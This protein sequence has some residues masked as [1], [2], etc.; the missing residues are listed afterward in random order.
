MKGV[1]L[2]RHP[3]VQCGPALCYGAADVSLAAG[4]EQ[5]AEQLAQKLRQ[6]QVDRLWSSPLSRCQQPAVLAAKAAGIPVVTDERLKELSF[7]TW[8]MQPWAEIPRILLDQWA[9]DLTGF[10]APGGESGAQLIE[11]VSAFWQDATAFPGRGAVLTHGGPLRVLEACVAGHAPDLSRPA[12]PQGA[13]TWQ[14]EPA[15]S[16]PQPAAPQPQEYRL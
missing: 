3:A 1:L 14:T 10:A 8:E 15:D 16:R 2:A 11:R 12:L 6:H 5:F 4:W 7:G 13:I 9:A